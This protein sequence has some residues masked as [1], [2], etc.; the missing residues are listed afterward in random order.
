MLF[1]F[2]LAFVLFVF[3]WLLL[4]PKKRTEAFSEHRGKFEIPKTGTWL[5][6]SDSET[7]ISVDGL[8]FGKRKTLIR[9]LEKDQLIS[10]DRGVHM[11]FLRLV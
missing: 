7:D 10:W 4:R 2:V 1:W 11:K 6:A 3:L 9:K 5:I 8:S